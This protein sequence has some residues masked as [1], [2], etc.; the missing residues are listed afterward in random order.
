MKRLVIDL[1]LPLL[2]ACNFDFLV[3]KLT[4]L[5]NIQTTAFFL[6]Y[7]DW[8]YPTSLQSLI[9]IRLILYRKHMV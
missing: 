8:V 7:I 3:A 9:V 6:K 4:Y 1:Q 5:T 2:V